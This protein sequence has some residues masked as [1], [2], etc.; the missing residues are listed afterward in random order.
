MKKRLKFKCWHCTRK[1]S[2]Q[3]EIGGEQALMVACPFCGKEGVV[4]LEQYKKKKTISVLRGENSP[5]EE[6]EFE[7]QLPEVITTQP[8]E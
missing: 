2:L 8:V 7:F 3:R 1:Y 4:Q 5:S 6:I